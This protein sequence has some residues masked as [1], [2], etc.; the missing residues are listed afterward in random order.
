MEFERIQLLL[1]VIKLAADCGLSH[2]PFVGA[3]HADLREA[4]GQHRQ[5]TTP[6]EE[7]PQPQ[8]S[9]HTD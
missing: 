5:P 9:T 8:N 7:L 2:L 4:G 1:N 3:A 6:I